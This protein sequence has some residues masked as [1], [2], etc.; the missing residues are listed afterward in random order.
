MTSRRT[1]V[2]LY[3]RRTLEMEARIRGVSPPNAGLLLD[4][5]RTLAVLQKRRDLRDRFVRIGMFSEWE[6]QGALRRHDHEAISIQLDR[7]R[8]ASDRL[9]RDGLRME[10]E[11]HIAVTTVLN[12][13]KHPYNRSTRAILRDQVRMN[14]VLA[15]EFCHASEDLMRAAGQQSLLEQGGDHRRAS[16]ANVEGLENHEQLLSGTGAQF[17]QSGVATAPGFG[18]SMQASSSQD[19]RTFGTDELYAPESMSK[20]TENGRPS[21][22]KSN[23]SS[24]EHLDF[25]QKVIENIENS[26]RA[27]ERNANHDSYSPRSLTNG[28]DIHNSYGEGSLSGFARRDRVRRGRIRDRQHRLQDALQNGLQN[29][30][31][32]VVPNTTSAVTEDVRRPRWTP[33]FTEPLAFLQDVRDRAINRRLYAATRATAPIWPRDPE[34]CRTRELLQGSVNEGPPDACPPSPWTTIGTLPPLVSAESRYESDDS[35]SAF[36]NRLEKTYEGYRVTDLRG[37]ASCYPY[38]GCSWCRPAKEEWDRSVK[39]PDA[40]TGAALGANGASEKETSPDE[41]SGSTTVLRPLESRVGARAEK[42][43]KRERKDSAGTT[44]SERINNDIELSE[45]ER[46]ERH[47]ASTTLHGL[48]GN[49]NKLE[50]SKCDQIESQ[51]NETHQDKGNERHSE[52]IVEN[53]ETRRDSGTTEERDRSSAPKETKE[54]DG[55]DEATEEGTSAD[56]SGRQALT[57]SDHRLTENERGSLDRKPTDIERF[58]QELSLRHRQ[59]WHKLRKQ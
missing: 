33:F 47:E 24:R 23:A 4:F 42:E 49:A 5:D 54:E 40:E 53:E 8:A 59:R 36:R 11:I 26:R 37:R 13:P 43:K 41:S 6:V 1:V 32:S 55:A 3:E 44:T 58:I 45:K 35:N 46:V 38:W 2:T 17:S 57:A 12:R 25:A 7:V 21:R 22:F 28:H 50:K 31:H 48:S 15:V 39:L 19:T 30:L 34:Q 10:T 56:E 20:A 52:E 27:K 14:R 29:C 16:S 18:G 51:K 9:Q